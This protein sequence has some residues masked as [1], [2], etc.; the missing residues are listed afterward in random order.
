MAQESQ[1]SPAEAAELPRQI[2]RVAALSGRK[3]THVIFSP[4]AD[5]RRQI[6]TL[7]GLIELP[8]L[9]LEGE[10]TPE[11]RHDLRFEG[12]VTAEAVQS[13]IV[14]LAPVP[15]I[16]REPVLRRYLRDYTEPTA[17][18]AEMDSDDSAEPLPDEIDVAAVAIEALALALPLYPRAPGAELGEAVFAPPGAEPLHDADL[19]PFAGLAALVRKDPDGTA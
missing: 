10:I 8:A 4:D 14:T 9:R 13:C 19:R 2:Y 3:R 5:A 18:E 11:G 1:R 12:E 15:A 6:A 17:E 7:L 16:L